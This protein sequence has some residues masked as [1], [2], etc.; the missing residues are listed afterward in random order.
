RAPEPTVAGAPR[1][2]AA[3]PPPPALPQSP[4]RPAAH[5]PHAPAPASALRIFCPRRRFFPP[6]IEGP[7]PG[8]AGPRSSIRESPRSRPPV[9][10]P[11][12][13]SPSDLALRSTPAKPTP[14]IPTGGSSASGNEPPS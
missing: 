11:R 8:S 13:P 1:E 5:N 6:V 7:S 2:A 4:D 12:A 10:Q 3:T 9:L 14:P